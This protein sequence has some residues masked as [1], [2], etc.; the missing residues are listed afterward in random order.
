MIVLPFDFYKS[1]AFKEINLSEFQKLR[2]GLNLN[3]V[4]IG[5]ELIIDFGTISWLTLSL[6]LFFLQLNIQFCSFSISI[7]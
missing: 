5:F 1:L 6:N 7:K 2:L 4:L 3:N